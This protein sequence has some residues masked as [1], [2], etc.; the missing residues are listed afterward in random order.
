[1]KLIQSVGFLAAIAVLASCGE[2]EVILPGERLDLRNPAVISGA[3]PLDANAEAAEEGEVNRAVAINLPG[4]V[5]HGAWTHRYGNP[6]HRITHP[7]LGANLTPVWSADI[8]AGD[9]RKHRITADP[10]ISDNRVFAMDARSQVSAF[11]TQ[12]A[13]LWTADLTPGFDRNEDATGGGL[14]VSGN[15]LYATTGFGTLSAIDVA[16]GGIRWTQR[17]DAPT[18]GAP[19]VVGDL[20]YV[21]SRDGRAWAVDIEEGRVQWELPGVPSESVM[22][23]G[24]GPAV[25]DKIA[26][27]P[28]GSGDMVASFPRGGVRLWAASLAGQRRGRAYAAVTDVTGDPVVDGDVVYAGSSSGRLAALNTRSGDRIWTAT[29]GALSPVWPAGGSVFLVSD[30]AE[31]LRLDAET[32]ERIWGVDLPYFEK[33]RLRRRK[34]VFAHYGPILAGGR[35][36]VASS[37]GQIRSYSPTDGSLLS[38]VAIS[39]GATTNPAVVNGTL[40]IVSS[41]G[42]LHAFR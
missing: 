1:M 40:Y 28:F 10:V 20:V 33:E 7:A 31:L 17:V 30:Q 23:G 16:T 21:V 25:T 38:S 13:R 37:D 5:N 36:I 24:A 4:Q 6:T 34:G 19:T 12:G 18:T 29:E 3:D 35:L 8:G 32:G 41:N 26:I 15:T 9:G 39:G 2:R 14:A 11:S 42:K 27:F 22:V